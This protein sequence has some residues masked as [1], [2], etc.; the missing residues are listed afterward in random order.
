LGLRCRAKSIQLDFVPIGFVPDYVIADP[1]RI[2]QILMNLLGN[3]IKFTNKGKVRLEYFAEENS[4]RGILHFRVVDSGIGVSIDQQA[5]LFENFSQGDSTVA[6]RFAGTGL[7]LALARRLANLMGGDVNLLESTEGRGSVFSASIAYRRVVPSEI[8]LVTS[9]A[10]K[11]RQLFPGKNVLVADDSAD[12]RYLFECILTKLGMNVSLAENGEE[13]IRLIRSNHFDIV[14]MDMQMPIMDGYQA[15]G[16][17]RVSNPRLP[18]IALT[19][20]AMKEDR[21]KC[22]M[23]GCR[24]Y[25]TKPVQHKQLV[26]ILR[27][28]LQP[29]ELGVA[30]S[31]RP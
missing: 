3:A 18:V 16:L 30:D 25:L 7:G 28:Y 4:E 11:N 9:T 19:A 31:P 20:H 1:L 22:M 24:D 21:E 12:N 10:N 26:D 6:R 15:T 17:L 5:R 8:K 14:L 13:A 29:P 2:R 27:T 23:A